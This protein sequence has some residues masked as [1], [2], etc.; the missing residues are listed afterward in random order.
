MSGPQLVPTLRE[1]ALLADGERGAIV[2]PLGEI[3]WACFPGFSDP[4]ILSSLIGGGG[5]YAITPLGRFVWGG[6]YE[7]GTLIWRS[8]WI[9]DTGAVIECRE[10]LAMPADPSRMTLLRHLTA[11]VGEAE[12]RVR[13]DLRPDF[14]RGRVRWRSHDGGCWTG[15]DGVVHARWFAP[16]GAGNNG[17]GLGMVVRVS[18]EVAHDFVLEV[19]TSPPTAMPPP[20]R[21]MWDETQSR[22]SR[23]IP[24]LD[25]C[26]GRRDARHAVAVMTG[27]T[28]STGGMVAAATTS[29]PERADSGRS[30]D[31]RYVWIRDQAYAGVAASAAGADSLLDAAVNFT[32]ARLLDDGPGLRPLYRASG[33]KVE[34][35]DE[36]ELSGYPGS[37]AVLAGN[38]A[39]TQFQ[40]DALGEALQLF[41]EAARRGR[42]KP[43]GWRAA[44]IAADSIERR[45][46][47]PEAGI[48]ETQP[49]HWTHSRL[50][51]S[52][53]LRRMARSD[54]AEE[55]QTARWLDV[56]DSI[57]AEC[58]RTAVTADG[59]W[60][61][62]PDDPRVDA[63]L[64]L[65]SLRGAVPADDPRTLRTLEAVLGDLTHDG[66]CYR[67]RPDERPL[68]E[69]EGAFNLCN[70]WVCLAHLQQGNVVEAGRWF[71]RARA[72]CGPPGLFAEEFDATQRQFR[73][74]LPQAF[75][76]AELL[77]CAVRIG[78]ALS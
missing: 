58:A 48:W 1:Q 13:L 14:G 68:G 42:L 78:R 33:E 61:R 20:A 63:A 66:Y 9:L 10:A 64:L 19:S 36:V 22:W 15:T 43:D 2:G 73:G 8:R 60:R 51:C 76:H 4:A 62:A 50:V 3:S 53:G 18:P 28:T 69:A 27:L 12:L 46:H 44:A 11:A 21:V 75:V 7:E 49:A 47:E 72:V 31:Y 16:Q 30:Y 39:G 74:N 41:A 17:D 71:E 52:A 35:E 34:R 77:E 59:R 23:S 5:H 6:Y 55:R 54:G 37:Q 57:L 40:L 70:F 67:F 38:H 29:L 25:G 24:G 32:T 45:W 56:A 26:A 65:A